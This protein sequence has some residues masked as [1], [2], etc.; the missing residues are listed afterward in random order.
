MHSEKDEMAKHSKAYRIKMP[1]KN[2]RNGKTNNVRLHLTYKGSFFS[3]FIY[4]KR[5]KKKKKFLEA[6]LQQ[7]T[8]FFFL[9][10]KFLRNSW[11]E[12][13]VYMYMLEIKLLICQSL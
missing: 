3:R 9:L 5:E 4:L 7:R 11:S 1:I 6:H 2:K 10:F 13:K 8:L 12:I